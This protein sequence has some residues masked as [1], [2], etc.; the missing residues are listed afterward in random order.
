MVQV[1]LAYGRVG[2]TVELPGS[3]TIIE[4]TFLPGL[5][6]EAAAL[7]QAL[8]SPIGRAPVGQ[9]V[10]PDDTVAIVVCDITRPMP[11]SR[12]LPVLLE[13]LGPLE[14]E[15]ITIFVAT[16][17][18]RANTPAELD[19]MLGSSVARRY[20]IVNHDAFNRDEHEHL[21]DLSSGAPIL[22]DHRFLASSVKILT[23]FIEPHFFAGFSGGP[24]MVAPGLAA[25]ETVLHLHS[26]PF[27]G[28]PSA[29][30]G[31]TVGN[32]IHDAVREIAARVRPDFTLDVTINKEHRITSV[33]AGELFEAHRTGCE[34]VRRT[35][36]QA[37]DEPF[38]VV[39]TTNSGYPLDLNLYQTVKGMS[40]AAQIVRPGGA[41][42]VASSCWDGLPEHG[43]YK[44]LLRM[45]SSAEDMLRRVEAPGFRMH[46]QWQGQVQGLIQK[47]A[48]V[49]LKSDG[50]T[51][52]QVREAHLEPIDDVSVTVERLLAEYGP[53][54]RLAVLPQGPQTIPYVAERAPAAV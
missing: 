7:R 15:R 47:K 24:K 37:V 33:F 35:A 19:E 11:T 42:V 6:D 26:A 27:I 44:D 30:W 50:L 12:V 13:E 20:P 3:A 52:A 43:N 49:F 48:R 5:P 51:P 17:T 23:G 16:G 14:P 46:D 2:L 36:M 4:P 22:L 40:A 53:G 54:A 31:V 39:V 41:I 9:L 29:T 38:D 28:H 8:R 21:G 34:F 10:G 1:E 25:L 32:P 45:S 18:H